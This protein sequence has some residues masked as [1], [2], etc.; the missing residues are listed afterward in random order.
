MIEPPARGSGA[1]SVAPGPR[2]PA[3][4]PFPW[5]I[6]P[7]HVDLNLTNRCN[8]ACAH[9][10]A[11]SG[12]ALPDELGTGELVD[13]INQLHGLGTTHLA[14]AGGE[15]FAQPDILTLLAHAC[16][17][18][19]WSVGVITNGLYLRSAARVAEL[20]ARCPDLTV[21][22]SVD[23]STATRFGVLRRQP[24]G[25]RLSTETMFARVQSAIRSLRAAGLH[26]AVNFTLCR[27]TLADWA[28]TYRLVVEELGAG[29]LVAIKFFP[30]GYGRAVLDQLEISYAQWES[31]FVEMTRAKL[32]GGVPRLQI[33]VSAPW[34][35]YLPLIR[36]G[37]DPAA[38]EDAWGYRSP[39][40]LPA[41]RAERQLGD[42]AGFG[43]MCV[44]A[45]GTAYPSVLMAG[46][47]RAAC[48]NVRDLTLREIWGS[49]ATLNALRSG[50][51]ADLSASCSRCSARSLCGG[52][53]RARA[54]AQSGDLWGRDEACPIARPAARQRAV[55]I[56]SPSAPAT[57]S[58]APSVDV[59]G[60]GPGALRIFEL[61]EA[62]QLRAGTHLISCSPG[63]AR[64]FG[65]L[66]AEARKPGA[67]AA[68]A[69]PADDFL[70]A[71]LEV[72]EAAGTSHDALDALRG[73]RARQLAGGRR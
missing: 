49:S 12:D 62:I 4:H 25:G 27:P 64:A 51:L 47:E 56:P 71:L 39:L 17:L 18:P 2:P 67:G 22:V 34:E 45:D 33:S 19:G 20:A 55:P 9:C 63:Q 46:D 21:N 70:D 23:G 42:P 41:Y 65:A 66:L 31:T 10:H 14:I 8:L 68:E 43:E 29:A 52:G 61:G 35:F 3:E 58:T 44:D 57:T 7:S 73:A 24:V 50:S 28:Q 5:A 16:S 37:I 32:D 6:G 38:A 60:S 1:T 72:L 40:R 48:G 69:A 11:A 26:T 15:P 13:V 30:G 36:A 59:L 54:L 53:S